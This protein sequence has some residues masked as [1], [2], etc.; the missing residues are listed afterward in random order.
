MHK[1]PSYLG[2]PN[3][4]WT[5][6]PDT[7]VRTGAKLISGFTLLTPD[8]FWSFVNHWVIERAMMEKS[9]HELAVMFR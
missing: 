3:I 9:F 2:E 6:C 1:F 8:N 5:G 4:G 7:M